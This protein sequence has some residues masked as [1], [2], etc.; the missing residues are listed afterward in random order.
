VRTH[1]LLATLV[2]LAALAGGVAGA[3]AAPVAVGATLP[4]IALADQHDVAGR[5]GP[6][7]RLLLFT[8]D[9]DASKITK[10]VL[11]ENGATMLASAGAVYVADISAMP[12][13]VT[14]LFAM[15]GL[16]KRPYPMLLDRDGAVTK[17]VPSET[18][19]VTVLALDHGVVRRV[20]YVTSAERLRA[21]LAEAARG[22]SLQSSSPAAHAMRVTRSSR[23]SARR[24]AASPAA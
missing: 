21:V 5:V 11:A 3:S 12:S 13:L 9:M 22:V 10:E 23:G 20:E 16:R 15:P 2:V 6:E 7:T 24:A 1:T 19:A 4:E 18:G 17:D 14:A 8:R